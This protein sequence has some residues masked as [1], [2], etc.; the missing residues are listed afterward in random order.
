[1]NKKDLSERDICT[2]YITPAVLKSGWDKDK[3]IREE[4]T[5]TDG[6]IIVR[7]K[8][9]IRGEKKRADYIIYFKPNLPIAIIEAKDNRH[10][11]GAGLQQGIQY[12]GILDIP[13][14]YSSNG[15]G[16]IEHDRTGK[17]DLIERELTLDEFPTP[18]ELWDRYKKWKGIE[19]KHEKIITHNYHTSQAGKTPRYYQEIAINRTV[20]KVAKGQDRVLL[21]MAT[22]TGKT[23]VAS[24]I[25]YKLWKSK[26]KKRILF[27]ADRNILIDQTINNDFKIFRGAIT[28]VRNR[29]VDKSYEIYMALYQGLTGSEDWKNIYK[30]FSKDFFDLVVIDEC[31]RGSARIDSA[32]REIIDYFKSATHIGLTATPK[33]TKEVSNIDYFGEPIYTYSLKQGIEDGFLAPYKVVKISIDRDVEGWRPKKG[34]KD[35]YGYEVEDRIYNSKDFDRNLVIDERT[36]L[37]AKKISELLKNS[38]DR[39]AKTIVFCVDI[40]HAERMRMALRNENADLVKKNSKYI[41]KITGDDELGKKELDSFIDPASKYPVIATTSKLMNTGI[42]AQTC[43]LIVLDSNI[44]SMT[45]FKQIIGRGTR[46]REDYGK[47]YFTIMDFRQVTD[48]FADPDFDGEP[49]QI[50]EPPLDTEIIIEQAIKEDENKFG[51]TKQE[52]VF[53]KDTTEKPRK[54]YVKGVPVK[55]INQRILFYDKDG[56]LVTESL[57]D[58]TKNTLTQEY[59]TIKKFLKEWNTSEKKS[60]I[61]EKL[62]E[63]GVLLDELRNEVGKDYDAFDLICHVAF[64]KKPLTRQERAKNVKKRNYFT[65]YGEKAKAVIEALL[66]KYADEGIPDLESLNVLKVNPL[67]EFGTPFEIVNMFGGKTGYLNAI[68][69]LESQLYSEV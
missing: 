48:L 20:E 32:W 35:K 19:E 11:I 60:I 37:V 4:K 61:I 50:Y 43:K 5:F 2:K 10:T 38:G 46:I 6:K 42:D 21:V 30:Q 39:F 22:G 59:K 56:K 40:D 26:T 8:K 65:K 24:Q 17:S 41:L 13:F 54:Y 1:M 63:Q 23:Y 68:K 7:G 57:Q 18:K 55:V 27:L 51:L 66:D 31:H 69:E 58:Y 34:Q 36:Q 9:I 15:D 64:D 29:N 47:Y 53:I 25:I 67:R 14:V 45:E 52:Q 49:V 44:Q 33:E 62:E 3:Q 28:K 12:G 16:F